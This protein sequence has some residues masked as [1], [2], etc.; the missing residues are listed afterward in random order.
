MGDADLTSGIGTD[1]GRDDLSS[2]TNTGT[3]E[4]TGT[5]VRWLV[6]NPP[7]SLHEL[8]LGRNTPAEFVIGIRTGYTGS[9]PN[10]TEGYFTGFQV[11]ID[12][13]WF[14]A[15]YLLNTSE[16]WFVRYGVFDSKQ[17][18]YGSSLSSLS[19]DHQEALGAVGNNYW[20]GFVFEKD[21]NVRPAAGNTH[22]T[23]A[24]VESTINTWSAGIMGL[25]Q[26]FSDLIL[27]QT[28]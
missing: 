27:K 9:T 1:T 12:N 22:L 18:F 7:G 21:G 20:I 13:K 16:Q 6:N 19:Y 17:D 26:I 2:W 5:L 4:V 28:L 25:F 24:A 14:A 8:T 11:N 10:T 3:Y 23:I 15:W